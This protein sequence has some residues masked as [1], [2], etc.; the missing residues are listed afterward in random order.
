MKKNNT[1]TVKDIINKNVT[2]TSLNDIKQ[3]FFEKGKDKGYIDSSELDKA[4]SFIDI[5][6]DDLTELY[7]Y[8]VDNGIEIRD[9]E[10]EDEEKME[11]LSGSDES[12]VESN[13]SEYSFTDTKAP[14][15]PVKLYLHDIG[16][17][18]V[19]ASKE[20]EKELAQRILAGDEEARNELVN[21]NLKL[22]VSLAK[23]QVNRGMSLLDLI[24]E[25]NLGLIKAVEKFDYKRG[26]KFST[27]ATWWIRQ[28]ITRALA[29][30]ARTI[31]IPVHMVEHIN[32]MIKAQRTL[33]MNLNRDPTPE[34]LASYLGGDFTPDKIRDMQQIALDPL[35]LEKPVG[36]EEDSHVGDFIE[37]KENINP[38]DYAS[39]EMLKDR[40]EQVLSELTD[41]EEKV[42]KLRY[43]LEDGR[44]H[45]LEEVGKDFGVTRE[46]IRQIEAKAIKKLR[47]PSRSKLLKDYK[48]SL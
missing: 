36:E 20:K 41:R 31:R 29:D 34:E 18:P 46:R 38:A 2:L 1:T 11:E 9:L 24:Q 17:Y 42:I 19:I 15:D 8:F 27:Y 6:D 12:S 7:D 22:V 3:K 32:K 4:L 43:G 28:S 47:H 10:L 33:L 37:D 35:S 25:G 23:H 30:Q 44:T 45:T 16:A 48:D 40:I 14:T 39:S 21:C 26:Y 13:T 5:D